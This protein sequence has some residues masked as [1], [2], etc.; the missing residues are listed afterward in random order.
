MSLLPSKHVV[1]FT[2]T[3]KDKKIAEHKQFQKDVNGRFYK[4]VNNN[5]WINKNIVKN[6]KLRSRL[7]HICLTFMKLR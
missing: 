2:E 6:V 5:T 4:Y 1:L 7:L 3:A